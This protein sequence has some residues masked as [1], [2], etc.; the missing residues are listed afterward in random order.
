MTSHK[1]KFAT[2]M[3]REQDKS[4]DIEQ[5]PPIQY[6]KIMLEKNNRFGILDL[7]EL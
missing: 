4:S 2:Y 3:A 6:V 1:V 7:E 5:Q